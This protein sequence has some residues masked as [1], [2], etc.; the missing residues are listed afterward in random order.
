VGSGVAPQATSIPANT[1]RRISKT[2]RF[3][4]VNMPP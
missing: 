3:L 2:G 1:A 4:M